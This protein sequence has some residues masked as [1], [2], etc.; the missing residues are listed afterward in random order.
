MFRITNSI[1]NSAEAI[2]TSFQRDGRIAH[3]ERFVKW[4]CNNHMGSILNIDGRCLGTPIRAGFSGVIRYNHGFYLSRF[5]GCIINSNDIFL[6]ELTAIHRGLCL[7]IDMG[8][9]DLV[10]YL[11]SLLS[12]NLITTLRVITS[13]LFS[14]KILRIFLVSVISLSAIR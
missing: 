14:F 3:P 12:I 5:T 10:C 1:H 11:D 6:V 2:T 4:N 13:M 9:D 7:A 8:L